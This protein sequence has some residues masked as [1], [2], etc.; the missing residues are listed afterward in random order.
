MSQQQL[1]E[2]NPFART[3]RYCPPTS[4]EALT[5]WRS[6][7]LTLATVQMPID[8]TDIPMAT[9]D[10]SNSLWLPCLPMLPKPV[11]TGWP[12]EAYTRLD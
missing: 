9:V 10:V 5:R 8:V 12:R 6:L 11:Q 3:M 1:P 2:I 4:L 7:L